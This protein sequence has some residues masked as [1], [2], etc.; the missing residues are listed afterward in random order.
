MAELV[1]LTD[2]VKEFH[3]SGLLRSLKRSIRAVDRVSFAIGRGSIFGLVGESGCGKTSLA[4]A[5]LYLDP[6][7]RG[8]VRFD[9][10]SLAGLSRAA[11]KSLRSRMQIVF[12]DPNSSLNPRL[13]VGDSLEEGLINLR[14]PHRERRQ[15]IGSL[16]ERVGISPDQRDRYPHQFSS[17]QKQRLII[18]RALAMEPDFL[19]L[20][21]PVSNLDVSIQAQIINLLL[22][23]KRELELTFLF[24]SHDLNL[25]SYLS[26]MIAVMY[27]GRIIELAAAEELVNHPLHPYTRKLYASLP[28]PPGRRG[29]PEAP[30]FSAAAE[31]ASAAVSAAAPGTA[32]QPACAFAPCCTRSS[33][34][35]L[36]GQPDLVDIGGGH[37]VACR[38]LN[39]TSP[40][41]D[42]PDPPRGVNPGSPPDARKSR[43]KHKE[44]Q[45]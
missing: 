41:R 17:G 13:R 24:I 22:D 8:D 21:E 25:V 6:P 26:D 38:A 31:A 19:V 4:R 39:E 36:A 28:V 34:D 5:L 45:S 32:S 1:E 18:A 35:C 33:E 16:L 9:G 10:V 12:Q 20:D 14:I 27:R 23:L 43:R 30:R 15:R 40:G 11:L 44:E 2:L 29:G 42:C 7:T 3:P 37:L